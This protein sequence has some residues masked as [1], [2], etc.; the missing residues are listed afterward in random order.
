[1]ELIFCTTAGMVQSETFLVQCNEYNFGLDI[2]F[3]NLAILRMLY[4]VKILSYSSQ[5]SIRL[6]RQDIVFWKLF[7]YNFQQMPNLRKIYLSQNCIH[8]IEP[9]TFLIEPGSLMRVDVSKNKLET[10]DVTNVILRKKFFLILIP[11]K[12]QFV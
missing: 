1:M 10:T 3:S 12:I 5:D 9:R 4:F 8:Y 6:N 11:L 7:G 2:F